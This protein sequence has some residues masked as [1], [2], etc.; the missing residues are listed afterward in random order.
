[1]RLQTNGIDLGIVTISLGVATYPQHGTN[2]DSLI[3]SADEASYEAKLGG[4]NRV[5]VASVK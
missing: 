3:K 1:M 5:V 4:I 2:R